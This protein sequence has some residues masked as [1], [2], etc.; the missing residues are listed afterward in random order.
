LFVKVENDG[1]DL[2]AQRR[3]IDKNDLPK[4]VEILE[5]WKTSFVIPDSDRESMILTVK[6]EKIAVRQLLQ[7]QRLNKY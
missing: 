6:K 1:F 3:E 5:N 4:A 2:G 7:F